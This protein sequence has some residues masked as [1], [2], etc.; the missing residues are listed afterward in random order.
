MF[1]PSFHSL[2]LMLFPH[3]FL[4]LCSFILSL[5][6]IILSDSTFIRLNITI[7]LV[8]STYII[9]CVHISILYKASL[10][11]TAFTTDGTH[12]LWRPVLLNYWLILFLIRFIDLLPHILDFNNLLFIILFQ[13]FYSTSILIFFLLLF[14]NLLNEILSQFV[15][16]HPILFFLLLLFFLYNFFFHLAN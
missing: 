7:W 15:W 9:V 10:S 12:V 1:I 3:D 8:G 14:I 5:S 4:N 13:S 2:F 11:K 16:L 6:F